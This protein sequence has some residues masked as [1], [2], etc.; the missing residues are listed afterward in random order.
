MEFVA[1]R[2]FSDLHAITS[3]A[4]GLKKL[5]KGV[6]R[7]YFIEFGEDFKGF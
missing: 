6:H 3:D 1:Q 2:A 7:V 4:R 5:R